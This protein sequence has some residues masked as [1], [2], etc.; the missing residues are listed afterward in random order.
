MRLHGAREAE[1]PV[2]RVQRRPRAGRTLV[3]Y[4]LRARLEHAA[5]KRADAVERGHPI[6]RSPHATVRRE[7]DRDA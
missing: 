5:W 3:A 4:E 7:R 1:R 2:D 6:P